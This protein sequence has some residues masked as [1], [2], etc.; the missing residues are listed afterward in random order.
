[1]DAIQWREKKA[2]MVI[3]SFIK[4]YLIEEGLIIMNEDGFYV[5]NDARIKELNESEVNERN[6]LCLE[7]VRVKEMYDELNNAIK[8]NLRRIEHIRMIRALDSDSDCDDE[9]EWEGFD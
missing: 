7:R 8:R 2:G 6:R 4:P 9:D 1:V 5:K 3:P